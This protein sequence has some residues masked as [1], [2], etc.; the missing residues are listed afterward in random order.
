MQNTASSEIQCRNT[1][2][3]YSRHTNTYTMYS[4]I[5]TVQ[6]IITLWSQT[7]LR[8]ERVGLGRGLAIKFRQYIH[9]SSL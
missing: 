7:Y 6:Q 1:I 9:W 5:R 4:T 3:Q 8:S 2:C